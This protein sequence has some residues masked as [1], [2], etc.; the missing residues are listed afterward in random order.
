MGQLTFHED[1]PGWCS[2]QSAYYGAWGPTDGLST[3]GRYFIS[4]VFLFPTGWKCFAVN[5]AFNRFS[6]N[7]R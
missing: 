4:V 2:S 7:R 6:F 1:R 3:A 5:L